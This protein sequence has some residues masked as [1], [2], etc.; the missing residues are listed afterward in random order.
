M[1][2]PSV[3]NLQRMLKRQDPVRFGAEYQPAIRATRSEAPPTSRFRRMY[4]R[5][6][7]RDLHCLAAT[8][9]DAV[10]LA[11]YNPATVDVLEQLML[12]RWDAPHLLSDH[13]DCMA[14][15]LPP[16]RGTVAVAERLDCLAFHPYVTKRSPDDELIRIAY[17]FVGD[18][19]LILRV[20]GDLRCVNWNIK[21]RR[22]DHDRP[23][24]EKRRTRRATERAIARDRIEEAYYR[25]AGIPTYRIAQDQIDTEVRRNLTALFPH[26]DVP[27]DVPRSAADEAVRTYRIAVESGYPLVD[28][29][30]HLLGTG[31]Y[32][33]YT[34]RTILY[35]A[36]WRRE[37][38][39]DLFA[40]ILIDQPAMP[41]RRDVLEEYRAW[42]KA[43]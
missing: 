6:H 33:S 37:L 22:G 14:A 35:A 9:A 18:L 41:E 11:L 25:D 40:P 15:D 1:P 13:P 42:F 16:F 21:S 17:P 30:T 12:R 34:L 3:A 31:R 4:W 38:R 23:H 10:L 32:T 7:G 39:L 36:I 20:D 28:A 8:E 29:V 2:R 27:L 24:P 26:V 43:E 19:L 5:R